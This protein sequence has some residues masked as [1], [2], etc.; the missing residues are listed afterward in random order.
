MWL[1]KYTK[2]HALTAH[3]IVQNESA[4]KRT[5]SFAGF[6]RRYACMNP[7]TKHD[8]MVTCAIVA[9]MGDVA[10]CSDSSASREPSAPHSSLWIELGESKL[11]SPLFE[12]LRS[13][14]ASCV[15]VNEPRCAMN[16]SEHDDEEDD[17]S[18]AAAADSPYETRSGASASETGESGR[19]SESEQSATDE[20]MK[21]RANVRTKEA[22]P[23]TLQQ[24]SP[25]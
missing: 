7:A 4:P 5:H 25:L 3:T 14:C 24:R 1:L 12:F 9:H 16:N 20:Q 19:K 17:D 11:S 8:L 6:M 23:V 18:T 22:A 21:E 13:L 10:V 2:Y 15:R